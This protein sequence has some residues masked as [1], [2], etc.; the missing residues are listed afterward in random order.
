M[1]RDFAHDVDVVVLCNNYAAG[2]VGTIGT[3]FLALARGLTVPTPR[4]RADLAVDS[5]RARTFTGTYRAKPGALPYGEG[6]FVVRW[7]NGDLVVYR[8]QT[9]GDVLVPQGNDTFLLRNFWS[10]LRFDATKATKDGPGATLRPLWFQRDPVP[11]ERV[12]TAPA[13]K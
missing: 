10:E 2:M 3:D 4:W 12:P 9:P 13:E 8:D 1:S 7:R 11:L 6:P 5:A